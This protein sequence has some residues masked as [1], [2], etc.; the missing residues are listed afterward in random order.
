MK[1]RVE[2]RRR[3]REKL[4]GKWW[5]ALAFVAVWLMIYLGLWLVVELSLEYWYLVAGGRMMSV[6][7]LLVNLVIAAPLCYALYAFFW[8]LAE[9][10][11]MNWSVYSEALEGANFV[12]GL[13]LSLVMSAVMVSYELAV[14]YALGPTLAKAKVF[15]GTEPPTWAQVAA[16]PFAMASLLGLLIAILGLVFLSVVLFAQVYFVLVDEPRMGVM[17]ILGRSFK[18]MWGHWLEYFMLSLWF[19]LAMVVA[20]CLTCGVGAIALTPY[21]LTTYACYFREV[22]R[23]LQ[24]KGKGTSQAI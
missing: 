17:A 13:G 23:D 1:T 16:D 3:A 12:R 24:V 14:Q 19:F 2:L 8:R 7:E 15:A 11:E 20:G 5:Q 9:R 4:R 21:A 6:V 22:K 18:L 10:G